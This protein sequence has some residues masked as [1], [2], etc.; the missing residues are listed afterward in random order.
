VVFF[1]HKVSSDPRRRALLDLLGRLAA[2]A[3]IEVGSLETR[4]R[5]PD[6]HLERLLAPR[7]ERVLIRQFAAL[8][9]SLGL[10]AENDCFARLACDVAALAGKR[11]PADLAI[12]GTAGDLM[13]RFGSPTISTVLLP[14]VDVGRAAFRMIAGFH[15]GRPMTTEDVRVD[16]STL[17]V[18]ESTGGV[19]RD[20]AME[21]VHRWIEREAFQ[22]L[23]VQELS[24]VAQMSVKALRRRY[25]AVYR[26]EPSEHIRRLR[27]DRARHLLGG[28]DRPIVDV[29]AACGFSSQAA[30]YNYFLRHEGVAPSDYRA[31]VRA[32]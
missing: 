32:R 9:G 22:G 5:N 30:F 26:M 1:G 14:G 3:R 18:R 7:A 31:M 13:A 23:T 2:D 8:D 20:I 21:R 15:R 17:V 29:A 10:L 6:E 24:D 4:G 28:T 12:L 16:A 19:A 25:R 11:V 27:T